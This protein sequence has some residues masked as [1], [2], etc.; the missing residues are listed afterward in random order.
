MTDP[1]APVLVARDGPIARVVLNRPG[2]LNSIDLGFAS[3][4]L[5]TV[6]E[7]DADPDCTVIVI[8]AA[9]RAFCTGGDVSA[10][11]GA[12]EP[13]LYLRELATVSAEVFRV[14]EQTDAVVVCAVDGMTAGAGIAFALAADIVVATPGA[15]FL[16]AYGDVGLV[17]DCGVTVSL[18]RTIGRRRALDFTLSGRPVRA[19]EALEWQLVTEIVPRADLAGRIDERVSA[20]AARPAHVA[21]AT[22]RLLRTDPLVH[23]ERLEEEVD[24]LIELLGTPQSRAVLGAAH[25]RQR[26]RRA[27]TTAGV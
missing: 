24:V 18:P 12:A 3:L 13:E 25:D 11:M 20:L 27:R 16:S 2:A 14:L 21:A 6:L 9:G 10:I 4:L 8:E 5:E 7:L 19:I 26:A 1:T 17:P 15:V 22:K 23:A